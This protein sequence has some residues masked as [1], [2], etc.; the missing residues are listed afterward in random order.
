MSL[1]FRLW[2]CWVFLWQ[3]TISQCPCI[4]MHSMLEKPHRLILLI[5]CKTMC[6]H[7]YF[8]QEAL[9]RLFGLPVVSPMLW[10]SPLA[11]PQL[12]LFPN[13]ETRYGRNPVLFSTCSACQQ[14]WSWD[15]LLTSCSL[16]AHSRLTGVKC[17]L[18]LDLPT[19]PWPCRRFNQLATKKKIVKI[20]FDLVLFFFLSALFICLFVFSHLVSPEGES[21]KGEFF[22]L[23]IF[24]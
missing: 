6:Q 17:G 4:H 5:F 20:Y 7:L 16:P 10:K 18:C 13:K 8:S 12:F 14:D 3:P 11:C 9:M 21:W 1:Y 2:A 24:I 22:G 23:D 15:S 19:W